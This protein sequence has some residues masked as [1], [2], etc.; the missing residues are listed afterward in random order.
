MKKLLIILILAVAWVTDIMGQSGTVR[1]QFYM[2]S[3]RANKDVDTCTVT[4]YIN[5]GIFNGAEFIM[6]CSKEKYLVRA[7][8]DSDTP[9]WYNGQKKLPEQLNAFIDE[10]LFIKQKYMEWSAVAKENKV[11]SYKKEIKVFEK[12][13][14]LS[15][16]IYKGEDKYYQENNYK[17]PYIWK[18]SPIFSV[19]A[20]GKCH[21]FFGWVNLRFERTKGYK[22]GFLY[23][24]PLKESIVVSQFS[25]QF[26]TVEQIQSLLDALNV[27][28]AKSMLDNNN[29]KDLDKLFQ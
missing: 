18:S 1:R 21:T 14:V 11:T 4:L 3:C 8:M 22:E 20:S 9:A 2:E 5:N 24:T 6:P 16:S 28:T 15:L 17:V 23:S 19:D 12:S 10:L 13:P 27:E 7:T 29:N 26:N 25:F